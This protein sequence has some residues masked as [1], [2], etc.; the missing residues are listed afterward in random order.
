M[1]MLRHLALGIRR[2]FSSAGSNGAMWG[3][4]W[5]EELAQ[6]VHFSARLL[7]HSPLFT[8]V[9]VVSLALGI[10]ANAAIFNIVNAFM[11]RPL[12][13]AAP[14]D[15][16]LLTHRTTR[17]TEYAWSYPLYEQFRDHADGL[18]GIICIGGGGKTRALFDSAAS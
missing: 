15:L 13:V 10:G 11:L 6:D 8:A 3:L 12:P 18:A 5:L 2:L 9:V 4:R 7:L 16:V 1:S 17:E 14:D